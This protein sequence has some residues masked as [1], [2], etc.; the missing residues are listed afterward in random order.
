MKGSDIKQLVKDKY[1]L[2][3]TALSQVFFVAMQPLL[4]IHHRIIPMLICGF[5][6]SMIWTFNIKKVAFGNMADRFVYAFGAMA[7]TG[8]GFM[9]SNFIVKL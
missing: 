9:V 1:I 4:I 8:F 3:F 6:I 5:L 2:F 7:G